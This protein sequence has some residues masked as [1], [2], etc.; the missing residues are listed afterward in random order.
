MGKVGFSPHVIS[1]S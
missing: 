1:K